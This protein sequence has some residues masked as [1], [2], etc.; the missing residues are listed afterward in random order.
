MH[1]SRDLVLDAL[2]RE[3]DA[4]RYGEHPGLCLDHVVAL[5]ETAEATPMKVVAE[6]LLEGLRNPDTA[7]A[8]ALLARADDDAPRRAIWRE[9]LSEPSVVT[10]TI[11]HLRARLGVDTCP[12]CLAAEL[13]ERRYLDWLLERSRNDDPSLRTN[14][15]ELCS[16]HLRDAALQD[17]AAARYAIDRKRAVTVGAL[18][19]LQDGLARLPQPTGRRRR[20]DGEVS[21]HVRATVLA[22]HEC[23]ACRARTTA[24]RRQLE[25]LD[26]ALALTPV[27]RD[28]ESSHGLC[29]HHALRFGASA[30]G[31]VVHRVVEGRVAVLAWEV[32]ETRRKYVWTCRHEIPG[33]EQDA[34]LR[35]FAQI[36]GRVL[37]GGP[38]PLPD[39]RKVESRDRDG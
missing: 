21:A 18:K 33:P 30:S 35:G 32:A 17:P 28:Y 10:S 11:A 5:G 26:A 36:D 34:W 13:G 31:Q 38:A 29:V 7:S 1:D 23:P 22:V 19:R 12:V 2:R 24:E 9:R 16:A 39:E 37:L 25:L 14:P 8:L 15:G 4:R 27:R 3:R 20:S 6:R